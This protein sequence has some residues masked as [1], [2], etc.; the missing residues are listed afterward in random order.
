M[1][2]EQFQLGKLIAGK[3]GDFG[4]DVVAM[5]RLLFPLLL[6]ASLP[7]SAAYPP[8]IKGARVETYA[9]VEDVALKVWI[10]GESEEGVRKPAVV[11]FFGGS[12]RFGSPDSLQRHARY[13]AGKGM[14]CLLADYRVLNRNPIKIADC[15][16]DARAAVSWTRQNAERLGIDPDRIA[17]GGASAGGHLA[18]CTALSPAGKEP[19]EAAA[20]RPNALLLFNPPLV[21]A[22]F[23]GDTFAFTNRVDRRFFGAEPKALSPIHNLSETA[24]PT[25]IAHGTS[26]KLVPITTAKAF[27]SEMKELGLKC[28]LLEAPRMSHAFHYR[29]PWFSKVM[30]GAEMFLRGLGW[31]KE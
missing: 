30:S 2:N 31:L 10:V 20:S 18:A 12:W 7:L 26:D 15:V 14:I 6:A 11:L 8:F 3:V 29:D 22:P 5:I 13:L 4:E 28:E 19:Q 24:P 1:R 25:W 16:A 23:E 27:E 21:M 9:E 17:A